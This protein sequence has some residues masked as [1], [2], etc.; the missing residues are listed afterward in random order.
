MAGA[1]K[2]EGRVR[3]Y[4]TEDPVG[5]KEVHILNLIIPGKTWLDFKQVIDMIVFEKELSCYLVEKR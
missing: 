1:Q 5:H 3:V 4:T 2:A